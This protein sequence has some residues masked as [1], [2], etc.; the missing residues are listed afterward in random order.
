MNQFWYSLTPSEILFNYFP[1]N[2][3]WSLPY[4][5]VLISKKRG[6]AVNHREGAKHQSVPIHGSDFIPQFPGWIYRVAHS[7]PLSSH[8]SLQTT[9]SPPSEILLFLHMQI[10]GSSIYEPSQAVLFQNNRFPQCHKHPL[11]VS[12]SRILYLYDNYPCKQ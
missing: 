12:T 1:A 10:T 4:F 2:M 6:H 8:I 5:T 11:F 3:P 9:P 7:Q